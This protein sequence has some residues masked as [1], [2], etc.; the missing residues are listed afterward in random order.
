MISKEGKLLL[1]G[2]I[3]DVLGSKN[4]SFY[5]N[6]GMVSGC[7]RTLPQKLMQR[8]NDYLSED[9]FPM[10]SIARSQASFKGCTSFRGLQ[11]NWGR[12]WVQE[13]HEDNY[14]FRIWIL[15]H[16]F[17]NSRVVAFNIA[18]DLI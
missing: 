10:F 6:E 11:G 13:Y 9:T 2:I 14:G 16:E 3:D 12:D 1:A 17:P 18:I 15:L 8:L 5:P 7:V 4:C